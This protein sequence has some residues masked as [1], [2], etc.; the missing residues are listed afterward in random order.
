[1]YVRSE[2]AMESK[3]VGGGEITEVGPTP[4]EDVEY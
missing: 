4:P 1:M 2:L 3:G